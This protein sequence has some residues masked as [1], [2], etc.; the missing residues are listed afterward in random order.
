MNT[1]RIYL[2]LDTKGRL[3]IEQAR[4]TA[5]GLAVDWFP[6]G[7]TIIEAVGRWEQNNASVT[8]PTVIVEVITENTTQEA[9]A[10]SLAGAYK[11]LAF[12]E[13]VLVTRCAVDADLV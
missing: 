1:L 8:E 11:A 13:S 9:F 5:L 12:Q 4:E 2:G 3:T 6:H 7:H 10:Y